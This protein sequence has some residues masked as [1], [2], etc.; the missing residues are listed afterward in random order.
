MGHIPG[1]AEEKVVAGKGRPDRLFRQA[2]S[3]AFPSLDAHQVTELAAP[4][5][6]ARTFIVGETVLRQ[7]A[8]A[9]AFYVI[10]KG[11]AEVVQYDARGNERSLDSVLGPG[12]FFGEIG[13]L[14]KPMRTASVR[15]RTALEV[16]VLDHEQFINLVKAS[17]SS[18]EAVENTAKT[19]LA[20]KPV[21]AGNKRPPGS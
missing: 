2:L 19:R 15:A 12:D 4:P 13:L 21:R 8:W 6:N 16:V 14:I 7:G 5:L 1:L 10:T 9:N 18:A 11:E 3:K 20:R 17:Q